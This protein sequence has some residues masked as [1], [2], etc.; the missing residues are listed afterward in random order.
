VSRICEEF[1]VDIPGAMR[2]P[3]PTAL[4]IIE[5]R[6]YARAKAVWDQTDPKRRAELPSTPMLER[7]KANER[8]A[9][10]WLLEQRGRGS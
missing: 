5:L 9:N 2:Q 8:K 4:R 6:D 1:Q 7:V 3:L 10:K